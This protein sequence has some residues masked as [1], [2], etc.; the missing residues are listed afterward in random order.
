MLKVG[1]DKL[2]L[3]IANVARQAGMADCG[4]FAIA[5]AV[6][7]LCGKDPTNMFYE[8]REMRSHLIRCFEGEQMTPFPQESMRTCRKPHCSPRSVSSLLHVQHY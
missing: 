3:R 4:L 8:Q 1:T 2:K 5:N 6:T 7:L